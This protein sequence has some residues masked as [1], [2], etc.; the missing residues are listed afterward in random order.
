MIVDEWCRTNI[1]DVF[2]CG[3][4]TGGLGG[5]M[6]IVTAVTQG[7]IAAE[8]AY[9]YLKSPYWAREYSDKKQSA[10]SRVI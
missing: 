10:L 4:V 1:E 7:V 8:S 2:A 9:K 3:D 5:V 6:K